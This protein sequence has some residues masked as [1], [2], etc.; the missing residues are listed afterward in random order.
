[1]TSS[2]AAKRPSGKVRGKDPAAPAY[3]RYGIGIL[4]VALSG[5]GRG[6]SSE[7]CVEWTAEHPASQVIVQK[8]VAYAPDGGFRK[9]DVYSP[10]GE[11]PFPV[12]VF[13]HGGGYFGGDK[14]N[15]ADLATYYAQR[16]IVTISINYFLAKQ[17]GSDPAYPR[18]M[19]D[20][21]CAIR[22][23]RANASM[24]KI[25]KTASA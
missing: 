21:Y 12:L 22:S 24:L 5:C 4:L 7:S 19:Q 8:D 18:S 20:V 11:G 3:C 9:G 13:V 2:R 25:D 15:H 17:D 23:V 16:G 6:S 14:G 1:M 10:P